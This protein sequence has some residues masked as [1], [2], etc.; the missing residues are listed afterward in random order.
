MEQVRLANILSEYSY[1]EAGQVLCGII[2]NSIDVGDKVQIDMQGVD[3]LPTMFMNT[4]FG[5]I[6]D[7][8]GLLKLTGTLIFRN[9]TKV[10]IERIRKYLTDY[11]EVYHIPE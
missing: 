4:S 11:S 10:Q 2:R 5:R 3:S 7:E 6:M 1:P 9:I 8:Y